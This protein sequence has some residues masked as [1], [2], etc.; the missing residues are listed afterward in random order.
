MARVPKTGNY[1]RREFLHLCGELA[2]LLGLSRLYVPEIALAIE[3]ASKKPSVIWL[4]FAACTGCTES[5]VKSESPPIADI[6]LDVISLD[7]N[8]TIMAPAGRNAEDVL[9][10]AVKRGGYVCVV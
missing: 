3:K 9:D 7:F 5:F 4:N 8:E 2:A 6:I 10:E 1:S